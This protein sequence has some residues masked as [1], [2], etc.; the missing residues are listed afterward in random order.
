MIPGLHPFCADHITIWKD[1]VMDRLLCRNSDLYRIIAMAVICCTAG[2]VFSTTG[3]CAPSSKPEVQELSVREKEQLVQ[4]AVAHY[5]QKEITKAKEGLEKASA[6]FPENY[7]VPYYLGLIY[8][9]QGHRQRAIAQWQQY[10]KLDPQ[11]ENSLIIRKNITIL[12]REQAQAFAKQAVAREAKL[13]DGQAEDNTIAVASF[14]NLGSENLGPLGKGMA[15]MLISDLSKVSDLKVVD[16]IKLQALLEEMALGTSGLVDMNTA[17]KVGKLLKAK[18]VTSGTLADIEKE[19]L[20]IASA[21]VDTNKNASVGAQEAKGGLRTFYDMEKQIACQIIED[22][23]RD[24]KAVPAGFNKVHTRSMPALVAYSWGL[25]HFDKGNY[26]QARESFQK[27]ID[28]D[29]QFDLA[30]AALLATPPS[31]M[32]AMDKSQ[33][34]SN[35]SSS[36]ASSAAAGTAVAGTTAAAMA[37]SSMGI[38]PTTAIIGGVVL[39]GGGVAMAGGGGGGGG[40]TGPQPA[41]TLSLTGDWKGSWDADSEAT[42]SLT[43]TGGGVSGMVSLTGDTSCLT[44]GPINGTVTGDSVNL[45]IQSGAETIALAA[46]LNSTAKTLVGTLNYQA[47]ATTACIGRTGNFSVTLTTGGAD[48]EW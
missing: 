5:E 23:G 22:L 36:G 29:P 11:S 21:V 31:S 17:P 40:E 7:A 12:L 44:T 48:I 33:M 35:A 3:F 25:D 47:S 20:V 28:E 10:V 43:Q 42:F 13:A 46:T 19:N 38:S 37:S 2:F 45:V 18:H 26:D 1:D 15:S 16:R 6:V 30:I 27:A 24:C 41:A 34:I 39:V 8:L 32:A 9:E 4:T 14:N